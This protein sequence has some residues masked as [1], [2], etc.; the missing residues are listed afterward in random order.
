LSVSAD[1][2][3]TLALADGTL[4][5]GRSFGARGDAL[6]E[7]VFCTSITGYQ[8][9]LT[10]PSYCGQIVTMTAPEIGNVGVNPEDVESPR[11]WAAG[12]IVKERSAEVSNWRARERLD[13]YLGRHG[14]VGLWGIDTRALVRHIRT[15]GAQ[16]GVLSTECHDREELVRRAREAPTLVGRDLAREVTCRE[17]YSWDEGSLWGGQA[18]P[19]PARFS[20]VAYDFGIKRHILRRLR[21]V[22]CRV[23]VVPASFPAREALALRP[24]GIF[25]SNGPGDPA[26]VGYAVDTVRELCAANKP[27]FGICLGHQLLGLALGGTTYKLKFGHRGANQPVMDLDTRKVEITSHNHGFAVDVESLRGRAR[28]THVN[29]NDRTVEGLALQDRPVFSV[30]YHP[31]ASPGPHDASYLFRR[32]VD[33]MG[34]AP[35][36]P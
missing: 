14:V 28:L 2:R 21:D 5:S 4:F 23:T 22:G 36:R 33:A 26:A 35:P 6:G 27:I 30:Q 3:C 20:V 8:E 10:D 15:V 13:D 25:L 32:F 19:P 1:D 24:D 34:G 31:E 29:L 16:T 9:I 17:P 11:P 7:V 18:A 12:L